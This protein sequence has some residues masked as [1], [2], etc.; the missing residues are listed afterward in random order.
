MSIKKVG[1][2]VAGVLLALSLVI[3][4]TSAQAA[5]R[6]ATVKAQTQRMSGPTLQSTQH[7]T[8]NANSRIGLVCH[9]RGQSV[10]GYYSRWVPGGYSNL[11]Y[12]TGDGHYVADIDIDTGSNSPV[13]PA[14][15]VGIDTNQWFTLTARH[16]GK[17]VDARG[18]SA[19]NGTAVQQYA[20][21]NSASQQYRFAP[22]DGGYFRII[23]KLNNAS[24][25]E[26]GGGR[27][28]NG[29][30]V[31][32]WAQ[33]GV[34]HQQWKPVYSTAGYVNLVVRNAP[35][36]CLDVPGG[37]KNNSVQLQIYACND[38]SAQQ[39]Q[40]TGKGAVGGS[41]NSIASKTDAFVAA[42]RGKW[43]DLDGYSGAQ[44]ADL[45]ELFNRDVVKAPRIGGNAKD[46]YARASA[47]HYDKLG[48]QVTPRK[49]DLAVWNGSKPYSQGAGHIAIVLAQNSDGSLQTFAQSGD[50]FAAKE[51]RDTKAYLIGYLR[52]RG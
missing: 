17:V 15:G 47:A 37:S 14:C 19:A 52:P 28:G 38:S 31:N 6:A 26:V 42:N 29:S 48:P 41:L 3:V 20:A 49:G 7:G 2:L 10:K 8:Y 44:C 4:P 23:S 16:S 39:F 22:T 51:I 43:I 11:W 25:I 30:K 13:V 21:N 12:R 40:L 45:A 36:M 46:M 24:N 9:E 50:Q 33:A 1:A 27:T 34:A 32:L 35:W 5:D 18:G